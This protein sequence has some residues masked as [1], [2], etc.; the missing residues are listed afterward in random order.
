M[1]A[2]KANLHREVTLPV[3]VERLGLGHH[4]A[5]DRASAPASESVRARIGCP[6]RGRIRDPSL[7]AGTGTCIGALLLSAR[8]QASHEEED[9]ADGPARGLHL[10]FELVEVPPEVGDPLVGQ[11][12][13]RPTFTEPLLELAELP[14]DPVQRQRASA[15]PRAWAA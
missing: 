1:M 7:A 8:C 12:L 3:V 6:V 2:S 9:F 14:L 13:A 15:R 4:C 5:R 11:V 10:Q